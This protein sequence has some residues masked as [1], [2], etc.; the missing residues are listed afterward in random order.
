[1]KNVRKYR[2]GLYQ[3]RRSVNGVSV[4]AYG[5]TPTEAYEKMIMKCDDVMPNFTTVDEKMTFEQWFNFWYTTYKEPILKKSSLRLLKS[6]FK[7]HISTR[8]R[9]LLLCKIKALDIERELIKIQ[10]SRTRKYTQ[11]VICG[12]LKKAYKLELIPKPI[13]DFVEIPKHTSVKGNALTF[14]EQQLFLTKINGEEMDALFRF[15]ILTGCRRS[16]ALTITWEHINFEKNYLIIP[17]TKTEKSYRIIPLFPALRELLESLPKRTGKLFN[18]HADTV[19][20]YFKR[21]C[22]N[23]TL[24]DLRHTFATRCQESG[25]PLRVIQSWLGH[26]TYRLTA[27]TYIHILSEYSSTFCDTVNF[28]L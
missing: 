16:E 27:D 4:V 9:S 1:M 6:C 14:E 28:K 20:H 11:T 18:Y 5:K 15:Y 10:Y 19:S 8:F 24:H 23:H 21:Y 22:H 26:S 3:A 25:V 13:Y 2:N 17:G 7:N 12:A